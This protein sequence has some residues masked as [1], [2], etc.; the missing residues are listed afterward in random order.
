MI[1]SDL[2][3][4]LSDG[5]FSYRKCIRGFQRSGSIDTFVDSEGK[6][7]TQVARVI[8]GVQTR[9]Y[10]LNLKTGETEWLDTDGSTPF[11]DLPPFTDPAE[12]LV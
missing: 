6:K 5:G 12:P 9:V 3:K 8:K 2:N 10:A 11:D 7:R 4:A 1:A